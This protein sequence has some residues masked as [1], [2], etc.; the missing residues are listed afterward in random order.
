MPVGPSSTFE[1]VFT[2][3]LQFYHIFGAERDVTA[4]LQPEYTTFYT[5][6]LYKICLYNY[7]VTDF[8]D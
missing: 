4:E 1:T 5:G 3:N 7:A 8:A 2:D 6:Y